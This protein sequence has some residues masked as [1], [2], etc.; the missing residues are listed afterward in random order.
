[1]NDE[2][3][4]ADES[5]ILKEAVGSRLQKLFSLEVTERGKNPFQTTWQ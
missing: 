5:Q 4:I 2:N 1:M 3:I